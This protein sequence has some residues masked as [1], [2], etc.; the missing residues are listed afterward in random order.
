M[1]QLV[2]KAILGQWAA[3][4]IFA[5]SGFAMAA[6]VPC[7]PSTDPSMISVD[8]HVPADAP[9]YQACV[10]VQF[11]S[12]VNL[13]PDSLGLTA[14]I[15]DPSTFTGLPASVT[16]DAAFPVLI[17][18]EPP[19]ALF[20]NGL[21]SNQTGDGNLDFLKTYDVEIH[22]DSIACSG[23]KSLYRM[24]KA[25]HGSNTFA[26]VTDGLFSGSVRARG[27]G[28]AFSQFVIAKDARSL[29]LDIVPT[30][31][32]NLTLDL[33]AGGITGS[34]L[35][36]LTNLLTQFPA[37][38]ALGLLAGNLSAAIDDLNE[39]ITDV[40]GGADSGD[41]ADEWTAGGTLNNVAGGLVSLTQTL[42]FSLQTVFTTSS[43]VCG[44]AG[45]L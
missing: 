35:T 13:T 42:I 2:C 21:E 4:A 22:T 45:P 7:P 36:A 25:P 30:K 23:T 17:S 44:I 18:I 15:I 40:L 11:D 8:V 3:V 6:D 19:V 28:G 14:Q 43:P 29:L 32:T 20:R 16:I 26:D 10:S 12:V 9:L 5:V 1:K 27:R 31:L 24:F 41:V 38:L 33:G 34:L 37:D 39:F